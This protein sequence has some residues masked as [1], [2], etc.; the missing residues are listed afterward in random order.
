MKLKH[1][2][3]HKHNIV[4]L[5]DLSLNNRNYS[6]FLKQ[7][8]RVFYDSNSFD[9]V[10]NFKNIEYIDSAG[11]GALSTLL[12]LSEEQKSE[13]VIINTN[14]SVLNELDET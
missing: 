6:D 10:L 1:E 11:I 4:T 14:E 8:K 2:K 7:I 5:L 3:N 9:L 12:R 13:L